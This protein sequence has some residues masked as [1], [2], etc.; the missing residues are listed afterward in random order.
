MSHNKGGI[1]KG[2]N[3]GGIRDLDGIKSRC[4]VDEFTDC[5]NWKLSCTAGK[6]PKMTLCIDGK[7]ITTTGVRGVMLATGVKFKPGQVAYHYK[8]TNHLCMNPAHIRVGTHQDKWA[9]VKE[10]GWL[11]GDP[12]RKAMNTRIKRNASKLKEHVEE[13]RASNESATEIAARLGCCASAVRHIRSYRT[14][15]PEV[16]GGSVFS[17]RP[18]A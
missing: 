9:H 14:H 10:S 12:K 4:Q 1:K 2:H 6:Y 5:W 7:H 16:S 11:Q 18:A 15:K 3:F 13:I 17:W 8:C